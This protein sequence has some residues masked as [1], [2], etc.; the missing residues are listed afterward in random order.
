MGRMTS[1]ELQTALEALCGQPERNAASLG[2]LA[3]FRAAMNRG[4]VRAAVKTG[5]GW[6]AVE[7]VKSALFLHSLLG[8]PAAVTPSGEHWE[9]DTL[10]RRRFNAEDHV[11][12]LEGCSV[13][14][15]A[16]LGEGV[17]CLPPCFLSLGVYVGAGTT[18]DSNVSL[19]VC[20]QIGEGVVISASTQIG[21]VLTPVERLPVIIEDGAFLGPQCGLYGSVLIGA[22]AVIGPGVRLSDDEPV[23]D[24]TRNQWLPRSEGGVLEIPPGSIVLTAGHSTSNGILVQTPLLAATR[25][26]GEMPRLALR[27]ALLSL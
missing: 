19:G 5:E 9:L 4:D 2:L 22:G 14:D 10:P 13:R 23:W 8:V 3:E 7:W 17:T 16:H 27:R 24:L 25:E 15:G 20:A 1:A 18:I 6:R 12:V 11:R 21:G 26:E